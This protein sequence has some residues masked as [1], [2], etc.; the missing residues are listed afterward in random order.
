[1]AGVGFAIRLQR[2][3]RVVTQDLHGAAGLADAFRERLALLSGQ[4]ATNVGRA[5]LEQVGR[6]AQ[7]VATGW[8]WH[9][10]P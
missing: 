4:V 1:M 8:C 7:D 5:R 6:L 2:L 9:G 10:S 3:T